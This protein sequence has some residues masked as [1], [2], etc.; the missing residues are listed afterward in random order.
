VVTP[1]FTEA[2]VASMLREYVRLRL[3]PSAFARRFGMGL[4]SAKCLLRGVTYAQVP[5]P[6]GFEYPW[7]RAVGLSPA[8]VAEGLGK[9]HANRWTANKLAEYLGIERSLARQI[10]VGDVYSDVPRPWITE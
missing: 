4:A 5:R 10:I 7:P 1:R 6:E 8:R 9:L 3:T 2:E